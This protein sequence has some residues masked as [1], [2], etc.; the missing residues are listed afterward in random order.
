MKPQ[1]VGSCSLDL[2]LIPLSFSTVAN[3]MYLA[4]SELQPCE[5]ITSH[6]PCPRCAS[7]QLSGVLAAPIKDCSYHKKHQNS[8]YINK[9]RDALDMS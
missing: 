8:A 7:M 2:R 4:D 3:E 5:L 6:A 9:Q 1:K